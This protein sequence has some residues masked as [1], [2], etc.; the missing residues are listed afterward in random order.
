MKT[1]LGIDFGGSGIKG[2]PVNIEEGILTEERLRIE[3]PERSTPEN[4][5]NAIMQIIDHFKWKGEIGLAFPALV[6][7]GVVKSAANIDKSWINTNASEYIHNK[8]GLRTFTMNDADAAGVAEMYFGE[9]KNNKGTVMI[10]T[11]GTGI[12][13]ALFTS[14][15]LFPNTEIGHIIFRGSDA[16]LYVSDAARKK[17][18]LKIKHWAPRLNEFLNYLEKL[19]NPGLFIIGGGLSKKEEK[20]MKHITIKTPVKMAQLRNNAGIIGAAM[21]ANENIS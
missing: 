5:V 19:F 2:A 6:A 7:N 17:E 9:G 13:T 20:V 16:E 8:T 21:F 14:G 3:T 4:V 10:L 12:G 18:G 15:K 11:I 1:I